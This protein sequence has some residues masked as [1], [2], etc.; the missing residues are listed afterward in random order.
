M[1]RR[2]TPA[3]ASSMTGGAM[4]SF[5][6]DAEWVRG[7]TAPR[8]VLAGSPPVWFA[9]TNAGAAILDA[10]EAG[11]PLPHG[12]EPLTD[13][14][15]ARGAIHPVPGAPVDAGLLTVVIP[16]HVDAGGATALAGLVAQLTGD[17]G[18]PRV[19]VVDDLRPSAAHSRSRRRAT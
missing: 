12:H 3:L 15:L 14:L 13:R 2:G 6:I 18:S 16:A 17:P 11:A 5:A 8:G 4:T 7:A 1:S 10:L 19:I 9:V